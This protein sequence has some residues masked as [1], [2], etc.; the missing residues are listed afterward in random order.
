MNSKL[1]I[2]MEVAEGKEFRIYSTIGELVSSGT[3]KSHKNIIDLAVLP[4]NIYVLTVN[5][6]SIKLIKTK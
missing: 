2:E 6:H 5:N 3:L 1:I 4:P